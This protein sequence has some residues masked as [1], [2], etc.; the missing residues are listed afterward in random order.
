MG[1]SPEGLLLP[2]ITFYLKKVLLGWQ[3]KHLIIKYLGFLSCSEL[4][5]SLK[6]RPLCPHSLAQD[7][8]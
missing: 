6:P 4:P 7:G 2:E 3:G 5:S 1:P 8:I